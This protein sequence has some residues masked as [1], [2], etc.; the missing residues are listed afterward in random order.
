MSC[1]QLLLLPALLALAL[2][3][4]ANPAPACSL[5]G[6]LM[7]RSLTYRQEAGKPIA[8][9]VVYGTVQNPRLGPGGVGV[10]DLNIKEVLRPSKAI[11]GRR[12]IELPR[13][14][15][16]SDPKSPPKYL[17][18][19]NVE[20]GKLDVYR[21]E[22]LKSP[23]AVD[24]VKK[25]LALPPNDTV[26][27]LSF[28]F[29]YLDDPDP[30]VSFDAFLEFARA[31]DLDVAA[32]ARKASPAK[33]RAWLKD[34]NTPRERLGLYSMMLGASGSKAADADFLRGIVERNDPRFREAIDGVLAG[35]IS[36]DPKAGWETTLDVLRDGRKPLNQR[37]AAVRTLQFRF[38]AHAREDRANV[39]K[40]MGLVLQHSDLADLAVEDL[41]QWR[42]WDLTPAVLAVWGKRG[43]DAPLMERAIL[44]YALTCPQTAEARAFLAR[45]R[46]DNGDLVRDVEEG[47]RLEKGE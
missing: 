17:V 44:R 6:D 42:L 23:A 35:Y 12:K 34:P 13:Y 7:R 47:L 36:L 21:G 26:G 25:A 39:L 31:K 14:L 29:K 11:A 16:V 20:D 37:L 9:V 19:A 33:V 32:A 15:P 24:Y 38:L 41:M 2:L 28:F 5:C 4:T 46:A 43:Y 8:R 30:K 1:R 3:V 40:G 18:F 45:R 10:S 27:N 22:P